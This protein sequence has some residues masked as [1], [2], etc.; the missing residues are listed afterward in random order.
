M[1]MQLTSTAQRRLAEYAPAAGDRFRLVYDAEGCGC[2]VSGV[3]SLWLTGEPAEQDERTAELIV[4]PIDSS[5]PAGIRI[6]YLA[7]HEVFFDDRLK[8]DYSEDRRAFRLASD[9]QIYNSRLTVSDRR[10]A[11]QAPSGASR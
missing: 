10:A 7:R 1:K 6:T 5:D 11:R 4:Q 9:N 3:A 8:L 2:A